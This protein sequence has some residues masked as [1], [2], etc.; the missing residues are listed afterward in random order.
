MET[1]NIEKI[2]SIWNQKKIPVIYRNTAN[3]TKILLRLPFFENSRTWLRDDRKTK[4]IW[5]KEKKYWEIPK[6]WFNDTIER[7]LRKFKYIYIIQPHSVFEKCAPACWNA[8]GHECQC[9]C[10]GANHGSQSSNGYFIVHEAFAFRRKG[11][12]LA[13]RLLKYSNNI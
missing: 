2:N 6:A 9:S 13:C 8:Q 3:G 4:P 12:E 5:D 7:C 1:N 10:L 11:N